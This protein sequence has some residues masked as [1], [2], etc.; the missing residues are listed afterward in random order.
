[1]RRGRPVQS[2]IRQN[3]Q[4][5]LFVVG[6]AYAYQIYKIYKNVFAPCTM[7]SV[8]YHLKKGVSLKEFKIDSIEKEKGEYSWGSVAEKTYY[9]L[10]V[11]AKPTLN[12]KVKRFVDSTR[13]QDKPQRSVN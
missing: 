8:Y 10:D 7:R 11:N 1:M 3:I 4:E 12:E 5:I 6:E 9:S 2:K 13:T